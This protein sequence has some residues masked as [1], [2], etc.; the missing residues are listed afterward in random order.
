MITSG[1]T[2][3]RKLCRIKSTGRRSIENAKQLGNIISAQVYS[4]CEL[5]SHADTIL[6]GAICAILQYKEKECNI[7]TFREDLDSI[8]NVSIMNAEISWQSSETGQ[9]YIL[10]LNEALWME[11]N[12]D[13]SLVN[14]NQLGYYVTKVQDNPMSAE[15]IPIVT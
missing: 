3:H 11:D 6:V 7:S 1:Q 12:T 8:N 4:K 10:V 9:T 15:P 5:D 14:P 2:I 13:H